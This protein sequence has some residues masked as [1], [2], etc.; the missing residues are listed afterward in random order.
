MGINL[1]PQTRSLLLGLALFQST[2]YE[3]FRWGLWLLL[4]VELF[5]KDVAERGK[6]NEKDIYHLQQL[7]RGRDIT[8]C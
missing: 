5:L 6:V 4:Y 8:S 1:S 2:Y 7:N 3:S